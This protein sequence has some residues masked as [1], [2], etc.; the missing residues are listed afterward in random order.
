MGSA[1]EP[2]ARSASEPRKGEPVI[3]QGVKAADRRSLVGCGV[4]FCG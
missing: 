2:P 1:A 4:G 3:G